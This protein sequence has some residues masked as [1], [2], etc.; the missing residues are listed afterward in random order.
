M[1]LLISCCFVLL[2]AC[3]DSEAFRSP[4]PSLERMQT[5]ERVDPFDEH[6]MQS[7]PNDTVARE[8]DDL[9]LGDGGIPFAIDGALLE[10]GRTRYDDFCAPCHG[11]LGD[12]DSAVASKMTAKRPP[13]LVDGEGSSLSDRTVFDIVTHGRGFMPSLAHELEAR[14]RWAVIAYL[15]A[16]RVSRRA[17]VRD[18]PS[19]VRRE[20]EARAEEPR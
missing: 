6:G 20:L 13:S 9:D 4:H 11:V 3:D 7:P 12:G 2:A 8:T 17:V 15:Q 14:D 10:K 5:Q 19:D 18:L 1:K 16:L